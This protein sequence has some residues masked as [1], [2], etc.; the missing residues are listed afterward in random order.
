M[1][2]GVFIFGLGVILLIVTLFLP[3]S[4]DLS[5]DT[6]SWLSET[7]TCY[8]TQETLMLFQHDN[9]YHVYNEVNYTSDDGIYT[10]I[11]DNII[12]FKRGSVEYEAV[13]EESDD[14]LTVENLDTGQKYKFEG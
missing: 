3:T 13:Y 2:K 9:T 11:D 1:A 5:I 14:N 7:Y 10:K 12:R 8:E 6:S 4:T